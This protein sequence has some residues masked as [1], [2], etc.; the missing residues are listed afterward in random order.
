MRA[1]TIKLLVLSLL[2]CRAAPAQSGGL[3]PEW[4]IRQSLAVLIAD[5]KRL[6]PMLGEVNPKEWMAKGAPEAY[7]AQW[8]ALR[9]EIGYLERT[10]TEL[11]KRPERLS[12]ALETYLRLQA[13]EAMMRSFTEGIRR[14]NNPAVA[15]LLLGVMDENAA[16]AARLR[17]YL[18]ELA[19]NLEAELQILDKE[20]QRCRADLI[21]RP[22]PRR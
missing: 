20:A 8:Q 10:A 21:N 14:Y 22:A 16:S 13:I 9:D 2:A 17:E 15:D 4:D 5:S 18:V 3:R 1:R 6:Q 12:L 11:A 19:A 7:V